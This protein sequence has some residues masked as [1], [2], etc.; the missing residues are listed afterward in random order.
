[1][2]VASGIRR[3]SWLNTVLVATTIVTLTVFVVAAGTADPAA[4]GDAG[5]MP[6][7]GDLFYAVAFLFVG[8]TGYGRIATLGEEVRDPDRTIP[9][10]VVTTLVVTVV[11]YT[12]VA[13]AGWYASG[14]DWNPD[15]LGDTAAPLAALVSDPWS[16]IVEIGAIVAMLGVIVNLVLGLSRVWLAMGRRD[17][18]PRALAA[19]GRQGSPTTAVILAGVTVAGLALIDDVRMTW[20]FSAFAVLLYYAVTNLAALRI[21]EDDHR[22]PRW[23]SYAGLVS[24]LFLSFWVPVTVWLAGV[25]VL[26]AG[27]LW[28]LVW[29]R[30]R[31]PLI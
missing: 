25:A 13:A 10:A 1:L 19:V 26:A 28:H 27:W 24:C 18:M 8:Y 2:A 3:T 15:E 14:G 20:S 31:T 30:T 21:P 9:R 12:A 6:P 5:D 17:D 22:F 11:L 4:A 23:I 29:R 16:R 7:V